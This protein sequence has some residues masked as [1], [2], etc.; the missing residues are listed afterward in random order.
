MLDIEISNGFLNEILD[1]ILVSFTGF[2]HDHLFV[3]EG[4]EDKVMVLL[5]MLSDSVDDSSDED[6]VDS[7][8][9]DKNDT[10]SIRMEENPVTSSI[11]VDDE[12]D[13]QIG[14]KVDK[15]SSEES[16]EDE[17]NQ[18]VVIVCSESDEDDRGQ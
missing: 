6:N 18:N 10:P 2:Y 5:K 14:D 8:V 12:L 7:E 9:D 16:A 11:N 13:L 15:N 3:Q 4:E 17:D 1:L